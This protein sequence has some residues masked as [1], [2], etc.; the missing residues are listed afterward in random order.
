VLWVLG[1]PALLVRPVVDSA[2]EPRLNQGLL[3]AISAIGLLCIFYTREMVELFGYLPRDPG[4]GL[5]TSFFAHAGTAHL[6]GN[7]Y[8]LRVFGHDVE[9]EIG[10]RRYAV[11]IFG[12]HVIGVL[13]HGFADP[14]PG[15][16][17]VGASAGIS[18]AMAWYACRFPWARFGI[19]YSFG[20]WLSVPALLLVAFWILNQIMLAMRQYDGETLT[21]AFGHLGGAA[22]GVLFFAFTRKRD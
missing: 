9:R 1:Y 11:L 22:F 18:G 5:V 10:L 15:L 14:R 3:A 2:R 16:P 12:A 8:F 21:S 20:R 13:V 19:R 6:L 4:I 7:L 17:L